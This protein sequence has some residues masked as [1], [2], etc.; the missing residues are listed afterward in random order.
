VAEQQPKMSKVS[1]VVAGGLV[2]LFFALIIGALTVFGVINMTLGHIFVFLAWI[3]GSLLIVTEIISGKPTRHKALWVVALAAILYF[4]DQGIMHLKA[5]E[6]QEVAQVSPSSAANNKESAKE[7]QTIKDGRDK[8]LRSTP[9][10]LFPLE[11]DFLMSI[12]K[13]VTVHNFGREIQNLDL[14][15]T[16]YQL[17]G[18]AYLH[19]QI[20]IA[21]FSQFGGGNF[22][23][24]PVLPHGQI[25]KP[26]KLR[27][28]KYLGFK[29][30]PANVA[31]NDATPFLEYYA[32]R[33]TFRDP[34][35][36]KRYAYYRVSSVLQGDPSVPDDPRWV[37]RSGGDK[38]HIFTDDI[39][40]VIKAH[41]RELY[42]DYG[43]E[44][45][46]K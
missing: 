8:P 11:V 27:A 18:E 4:G 38:A 46:R 42:R 34:E 31:A 24:V 23:N 29:D 43:E 44:E 20:K 5:H 33:F 12:D 9:L 35:I 41:Q 40:S 14:R 26:L 22:L 15:L 16:H 21:Q 17:D 10:K 39:P 13:A 28:I 32:L 7:M 25:T 30:F 36:G 3:V 6:H 45:Y 37:A 1:R 19:G 2:A